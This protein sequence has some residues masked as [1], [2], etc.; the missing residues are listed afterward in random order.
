MTEGAKATAYCAT[1]E[2]N[3]RR[4]TAIAYC[5]L[6]IPPYALANR[7]DQRNTEAP[8]LVDC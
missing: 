2:S 3:I 6:R 7:H 1:A 5:A 4:N 8:F